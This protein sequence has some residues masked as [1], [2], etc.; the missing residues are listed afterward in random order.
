MPDARMRHEDARLEREAPLSKA[1]SAE[2]TRKVC[3]PMRDCSGLVVF[4]T[5]SFWYCFTTFV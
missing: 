4:F 5:A 2:R 3:M 1:Q